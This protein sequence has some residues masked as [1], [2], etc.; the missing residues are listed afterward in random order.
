M[1]TG[2]VSIDLGPG[3]LLLLPH[4]DA[5]RVTAAGPDLPTT[6][7]QGAGFA[8]RQTIGAEPTLDLFCGHYLFGPGAGALLFR[9][10]PSAVEVSL[11]PAALELAEVLRTEARFDGPGTAAI[12]A[13]LLDALLGMTLRS[14]PDQRLGTPALWTAMGDDALGRA[15]SAVVDRPS[16]KWMIDRLAAEASMSRATFVRHFT[17]RTGSTVATVLT[18]I[19]MMAAA[20]LLLHSEQSVAQVARAVGYH[21]ESSFTEAFRTA[22]GTSPATH[23][24]TAASGPPTT[25]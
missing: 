17:A 22:L 25:S 9:L 2:S 7:E 13:A 20:D 4:G 23:R 24:T 6:V 10:M 1:T 12:V 15:I 21:S 11:D 5:H 8:T 3:D 16:E 19:R 18:T 14:R